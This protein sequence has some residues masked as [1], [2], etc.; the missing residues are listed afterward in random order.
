MASRKSKTQRNPSRPKPRP[1]PQSVAAKSAQ[2]RDI[3]EKEFAGIK[4]TPSN[5]ERVEDVAIFSNV[6]REQLAEEFKVDCVAVIEAL[7][8]TSDGKFDEANEKLR[9]IARSSPYADWRLFV[10]GLCAFYLSDFETARQN[11]QR[12]D[13]TR[14]PARIAAVLLNAELGESLP[15]AAKAPQKLVSAAKALLHRSNA[16]AA[17]K[18]ILAVKHRDSELLFS[19]SQVAMLINFR[20]D[21]RRADPDFVARFSHACVHLACHQPPPDAFLLLQRSVPGP[22]HDP[23]WALQQFV[24][25]RDFD[26]VDDLREE[27]AFKYIDKILPTVTH[28]S[29]DQKAALASCMLADLS[30]SLMPPSMGGMLGGFFAGRIDYKKHEKLLDLA[31]KKYPANRAAHKALLDI[32][33]KQ[34]NNRYLKKP[35]LAAAES[36]LIAAKANFVAACPN[37]IELSLELVDHYFK[38]DKL[39]K[40]AELVKQLSTQRVDSPLAKALPWKIQLLTA[41]HKSRKKSELKEV[42]Q[43]LEAAKLLWPDWLPS[44]WLP[45][46]QAAVEL[47]NGDSAAF[48]SLDGAARLSA[49]MSEVVGDTMS[50]AAMQQMNVPAAT[51]RPY[52]EIVTR[53]LDAAEEMPFDDLVSICDFFW[54]LTRAGMEHKGFRLQA[55]KFGKA[56][57]Q[58]MKKG[59]KAGTNAAFINAVCLAA[60]RGFWGQVDKDMPAWAA[61]LANTEV[62]ILASFFSSVIKSSSAA[63]LLIGRESQITLLKESARAEKDTFYRYYFEHVAELASEAIL[64]ANKF[65]S[66]WSRPSGS[67]TPSWGLESDEDD[68]DETCNCPECRAAR[69]RAAKSAGP[70]KQKKADAANKSQPTLFADLFTDDD[71]DDDDEL[72][73]LF[74]GGSGEL[75][76]TPNDKAGAYAPFPAEAAS[77]DFADVSLPVNPPPPKPKTAAEKKA[78][79]QK[80]RRELEKKKKR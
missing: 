51:I 56:F 70:K 71:V 1:V 2:A 25:L 15:N 63:Y 53:Y 38:E 79:F 28:L 39:D 66:F 26:G 42:R 37:E 49:G 60:S 36:R 31:V 3:A 35:Q 57:V 23:N 32:L 62:K 43:S 16:I 72:D 73:D 40:A 13:A 46:L 19:T 54:H 11:W 7:Q 12:L 68:F 14:R 18:A 34:V 64:E 75:E 10:R 69:A 48:Q 59:Q 33:E 76:S 61:R 44:T 29:P 9:T 22:P 47:R 20:D 55:S 21:F 17:A 74:G 41:M 65:T 30:D 24:Y 78:D 80:R 52:R 45:F 8:L 27:V 5:G 6:G 77:L 4:P 67:A 50:F 58:R